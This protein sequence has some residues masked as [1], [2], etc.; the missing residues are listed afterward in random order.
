MLLR[1]FEPEGR[2]L[3]FAKADERDRTVLGPDAKQCCVR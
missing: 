2:G 3:G 1:R